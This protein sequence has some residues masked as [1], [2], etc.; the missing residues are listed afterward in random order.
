MSDRHQ[1][2]DLLLQVI[3]DPRGVVV[4][5]HGKSVAMDPQ[6]LLDPYLSE[7]IVRARMLRV[8]LMHDFT[9]LD[10]FNSST[11][12]TLLRHFRDVERHEVPIH[13]R[14]SKAQRWQRTFFDAFGCA[15]E[16]TARVR[17]EPIGS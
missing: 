3:V 16:G 8:G 12:S 4:Q 9:T 15:R 14:Y 11:I 17:I 5:W 6:S 10:F 7:V 1:L 2:G 13:I